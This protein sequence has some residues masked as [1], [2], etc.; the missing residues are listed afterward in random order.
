M[1][2]IKNESSDL[3]KLIEALS[4]ITKIRN[5]DDVL[6]VFGV[7]NLPTAQKYGI[8]FGCIVFTVTISTVMFLLVAGGSL[9]RI[10]EQE[11][12]GGAVIPDAVEERVGRPLLLERLLEAQER[13]SKQYPAEIRGEDMTSLTK[14]LLNIAPDVAK[15]QEITA[16]L[17]GDDNA[18]DQKKKEQL[19]KF[20]PDGYEEN[21]IYAY[22][23]CQD[24]PGGE[25]FWSFPY[26]L[27]PGPIIL[28]CSIVSLLHQ[29]LLFPVSPR[30][31]LKHSHVLMQ[32]VE[33]SHLLIIV[34]LMHVCM[35][36]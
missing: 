32:D 33:V 11:K 18:D 4:F 27:T 28:M 1:P 24:K 16:S 12:H 31:D 34:A 26:S 21:Y 2:V 20:I 36:Q 29:D 30:P 14:I 6:A 35:K 23:R 3:E 15:A 19:K 17:V 22:R 9:K 7:E 25:S 13:L 5:F 10:A 8:L